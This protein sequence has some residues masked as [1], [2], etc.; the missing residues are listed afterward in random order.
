[1]LLQGWGLKVY[2]IQSS[3]F[4]VHDSASS[5]L[6]LPS[7]GLATFTPSTFIRPFEIPHG[8]PLP[9]MGSS[10]TDFLALEALYRQASGEPGTVLSAA[11]SMALCCFPK[12]KSQLWARWICHLQARRRSSRGA[13]SNS[14]SAGSCHVTSTFLLL[15]LSTTSEMH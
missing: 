10:S 15:L 7:R 14:K 13:S 1:M 3:G 6:L 12:P 9:K 4:R 11:R 2:G 8:E 5:L